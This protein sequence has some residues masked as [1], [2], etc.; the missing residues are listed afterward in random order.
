M[1]TIHA[2]VK[3]W[4]RREIR[5]RFPGY[6]F[7]FWDFVREAVV[8]GLYINQLEQLK[9][10]KGRELLQADRLEDGKAEN[11]APPPI[12]PDG[13]VRIEPAD[14]GVLKVTARKP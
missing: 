1:A 3:G 2:E 8:S 10:S 7:P 12:V 14:G 11:V 5:P 13:P 6:T 9:T 4:R